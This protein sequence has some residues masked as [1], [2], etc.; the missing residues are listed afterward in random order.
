MIFDVQLAISE[1][2]CAQLIISPDFFAN[3]LLSDKEEKMNW[4]QETF[5]VIFF[6]SLFLFP[7]LF[8]PPSLPLC[9]P[10]EI[11][12]RERDQTN[13]T[14]GVI[15]EGGKG[16]I[17]SDQPSRNGS[18]VLRAREHD[19][20]YHA[21]RWRKEGGFELSICPVC[22]R[23]SGSVRGDDEL[24]MM[25]WLG[26]TEWRWQDVCSQMECDISWK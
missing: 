14:R 12:P 1:H 10:H 17:M 20:L 18:R 13:I 6:P 25:L 21:G 19:W 5:S 11:E 2:V 7:A 15:L 23:V 22:L 24:N 16:Q 8:P 4:T 3:F 26:Q 9:H